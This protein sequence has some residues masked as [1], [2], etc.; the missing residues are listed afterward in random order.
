MQL[1]QLYNIV[2]IVI[3][4]ELLMQGKEVI[5]KKKRKKLQ[6]IDIQV[7]SSIESNEYLIE[8]SI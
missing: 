3:N 2:L 5:E 7:F 8:K 1:A 4:S 6:S